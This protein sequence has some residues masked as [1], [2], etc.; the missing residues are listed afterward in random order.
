M[1]AIENAA[2]DL[3]GYVDAQFK[4]LEIQRETTEQWGY[5]KL[6]V[7]TLREDEIAKLAAE[8]AAWSED[9]AVDEALQI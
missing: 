8:G 9:Q 6:G 7:M 3:L 5:E 4:D 2:R 1:A